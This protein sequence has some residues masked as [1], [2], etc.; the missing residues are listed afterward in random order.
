MSGPHPDFDSDLVDL[1]GIDLDDLASLEDS[2]LKDA[3][4]RLADEAGR[5]DQATAGFNASI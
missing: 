1:T 3:L 4:A 5:P 2:V